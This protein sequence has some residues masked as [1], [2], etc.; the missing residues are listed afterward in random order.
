MFSPA[1]SQHFKPV[2]KH[3]ETINNLLWKEQNCFVT[4]ICVH[5]GP[6]EEADYRE[7]RFLWPLKVSGLEF[8]LLKEYFTHQNG[9]LFVSYSPCVALSL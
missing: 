3:R 6:K 2:Q 4:E 9:N 1:E 5:V 8:Y 7:N